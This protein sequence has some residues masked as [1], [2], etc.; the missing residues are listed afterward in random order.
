MFKKEEIRALR[1]EFWGNFKDH[2]KK[3]RSSNGRKMNWINYPS[4][5][6][7]IYIRLHAEKNFA[8][9]SI[10]IQPKDDGVR[11]IVWEQL[12]ELR[13][14]L[15]SEMGEDGQWIDDFETSAGNTISTV[16]WTLE[17]VSFFKKED[18]KQI[19][20]FLENRLLT[21]DAFYQEFKDILIHL[22]D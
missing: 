19:F 18:Q 1:T 2:M 22:A 3:H 20:K 10:D 16:R 14:V 8:A 5:V 6:D 4:D 21:F 11:A 13:K 15:E 7:F 12:T 17:G 9:F